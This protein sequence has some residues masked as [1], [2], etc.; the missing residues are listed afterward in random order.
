MFKQHES[1]VNQSTLNAQVHVYSCTAATIAA[2]PAQS[3]GRCSNS[4]GLQWAAQAF[5][6]GMQLACCVCYPCTLP[7]AARDVQ[8]SDGC[9]PTASNR[10]QM[11]ASTYSSFHPVSRQLTHSQP[12]SSTF[13]TSVHNAVPNWG[14]SH[15]LPCCA[16]C[17]HTPSPVRARRL[18]RSCTEPACIACLLA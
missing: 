9:G 18:H 4:T 8:Q 1:V 5:S 17:N 16:A 6:G 14:N 15:C 11:Q 3:G 12:D 13:I 2:V 7:A 10:G